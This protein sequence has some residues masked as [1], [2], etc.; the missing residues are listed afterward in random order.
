MDQSD[1]PA[2]PASGKAAAFIFSIFP[3]LDG[4]HPFVL[5]FLTFASGGWMF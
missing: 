1:S 4:F 2:P 5:P 3:V